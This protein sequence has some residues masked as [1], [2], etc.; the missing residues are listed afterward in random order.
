MYIP[1]LSFSQGLQPFGS[2]DYLLFGVE[3]GFQLDDGLCGFNGERLCT[4]MS[5]E[6][7]GDLCI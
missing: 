4:L 1:K 2:Y 7:L 3:V 5:Q 6:L